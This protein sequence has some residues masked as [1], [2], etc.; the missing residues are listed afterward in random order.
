MLTAIPT[1]LAVLAI[2]MLGYGLS[3]SPLTNDDFWRGAARVGYW[4]FFPVLLFRTITLMDAPADTIWTFIYLLVA[5]LILISL[6]VWLLG[7]GAKV[8]NAAMGCVLQGAFRHN[9]FIALA[10]VQGLFGEAGLVLGAIAMSVLVVPSNVMAV[11]AMAFYRPETANDG[12]PMGRYILKEIARNP[13]II[14]I[15]LALIMRL[16]S[17][18]IPPVLDEATAMLSQSALTF[19]LLT[20]GAGL[21]FQSLAGR[22]TPLLIAASAK[23]IIF[24]ALLLGGGVFVGLPVETLIILA[25]FGSVPTAASS[26]T[27]AQEMRGDAPLMADI[28]MLQ[29]LLAIPGLMLWIWIARLVA[30]I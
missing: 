11:I 20:V 14:A 4:V 1:I 5:G 30:A 12:Q 13:L 10:V 8:T 28:I 21:R 17:W 18:P 24:P 7:K 19:M 29:T 22:I 16:F 3:R 9:G 2:L 15:I 6:I 26:Y 25:I 23:T 27:L